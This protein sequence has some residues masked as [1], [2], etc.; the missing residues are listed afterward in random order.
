MD[1]GYNFWSRNFLF[2]FSSPLSFSFFFPVMNTSVTYHFHFCSHMEFNDQSNDS[3]KT[4]SQHNSCSLGE[5][6]ALKGIWWKNNYSVCWLLSCLFPCFLLY[7]TCSARGL[8][9]IAGKFSSTWAMLNSCTKGEVWQRECWWFLCLWSTASSRSLSLL[10]CQPL[11]IVLLPL[12][13]HSLETPSLHAT[14]ALE[15]CWGGS[16]PNSS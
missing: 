13:M 15:N 3:L 10:D 2:F 4:S 9:D 6:I 11:G 7:T 5:R 1:I 8:W 14:D 12:G 16:D